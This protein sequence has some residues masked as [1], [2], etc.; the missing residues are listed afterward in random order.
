MTLQEQTAPE[1]KRKH[2]EFIQGVIN[3]LSSNSFLFKGWSITLIAAIFTATISSKENNI[4]W[5][6]LIITLIFWSIDAYYL[7]L[8]RAYR[9]LYVKV[10]K[11]DPL[12]IDYG[13]KPNGK[14]I[15]AKAWAAAFWRPSMLMFYGVILLM[16]ICF[17]VFSNFDIGFMI[18]SKE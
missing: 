2:L 11:S 10:S 3:R 18:R 17:I 16:V 13:M 8:E 15:G 14:H 7:M 4:S 6:G 12:K 9:K 5:L 1:D